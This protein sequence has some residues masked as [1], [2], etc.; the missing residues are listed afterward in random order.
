ME[1]YQVYRI[2]PEK[3]KYYVTAEYKKKLSFFPKEKYFTTIK[4]LYVGRFL[5]ELS[6]G[7]GDG[8]LI[9]YY[10]YNN[11]IKIILLIF[12]FFVIDL[13]LLPILIILSFNSN[14]SIFS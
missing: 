10:F 4:P 9:I 7:F 14:L 5:Y 11:K 12:Y 2:N 8:K 6:S 3:N 1:E 13:S